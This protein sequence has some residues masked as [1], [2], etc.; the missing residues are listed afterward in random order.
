MG[1]GIGNWQS[2]RSNSIDSSLEVGGS[3]D[4]YSA[5]HLRECR[6]RIRKATEAQYLMKG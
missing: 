1:S 2:W 6:E 3:I 4:D 5:S